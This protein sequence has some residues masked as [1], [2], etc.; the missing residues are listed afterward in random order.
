VCNREYSRIA[1]GGY[2]WNLKRP[3]AKLFGESGELTGR[4]FGSTWVANDGS[5]VSAMLVASLP[6][7]DSGSIAWLLLTM[8]SRDSAGLMSRVESLQRLDTK[9]GVVPAAGCG[10][11]N[12]NEEVAVPY[13]ANYYFYGQPRP[14]VLQHT[15]CC[16]V[17]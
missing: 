13:E 15:S 4:H 14:G 16:R 8:T 12:V 11:T 17:L 5:R 2:T 7:P 9:G 6:S 3:E 10:A 1:V